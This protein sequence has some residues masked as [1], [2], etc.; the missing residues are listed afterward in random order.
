M[1]RH[2]DTE[3]VSSRLNSLVEAKRDRDLGRIINLLRSGL[4]RNLGNI[5][6]PRLYN[7]ALAGTKFVIEDYIAQ[8]TGAVEDITASPTLT[9][10]SSQAQ[11]VVNTGLDF[12]DACLMSLTTQT[13]LDL[14][15]DTR[16]AFGRT[17]LVLQGGAIFGLCHLGVMKA[18][19]LRGLL[20]RIIMG[21]ATGALAAAL[22][23]SRKEEDLLSVLRGDGID[24]SAFAGKRTTAEAPEQTL[25]TRWE[26]LKRRLRR[27]MREGYFLDVKVLEDCI[28]ANV[29]ELT[30]DEAYRRSGRILNITV[31][32]AG[33]DGVPTLMNYLTTPHVVRPVLVRAFFASKYF[34]SG[35]GAC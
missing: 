31:P 26:T 1:S 2:F 32:T 8:V 29:G 34:C 17:T 20:P 9:E 24:L 10:M 7:K 22:V 16:Q 27:F 21:S 14:I 6:S 15:H 5:T 11:Q 35:A 12:E 3:L 23:G 28:R 13:K 18:L 30:F 4:V 19:L 33:R 25:R